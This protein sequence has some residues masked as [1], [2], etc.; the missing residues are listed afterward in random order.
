MFGVIL[1]FD[2]VTKNLTLL[3]RRKF[4][5]S[6][7]VYKK[8]GQFQYRHQ[9]FTPGPIQKTMFET[10]NGNYAIYLGQ[11]TEGTCILE[12]IGIVVSSDGHTLK[13]YNNKT[14]FLLNFEF[15]FKSF[16]SSR[17]TLI[18]RK[19]TLFRYL[20]KAYLSRRYLY[21]TGT[22]F[23][24]LKIKVGLEEKKL[25]KFYNFSKITVLYMRDIGRIIKKKEMEDIQQMQI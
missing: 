18:L 9:D 19:E 14:V 16:F 10:M 21:G 12:G 1:A 20:P 22:H 24:F 3:Y 13:L 5:K 25:L 4:A 15:F 23:L 17:P 11:L 7:R 2:A 6:Y 8:L